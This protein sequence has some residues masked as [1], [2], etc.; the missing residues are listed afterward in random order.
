MLDL[1]VFV[2]RLKQVIAWTAHLTQSFDFTVNRQPGNLGT[3][4]RQLNPLIDG[5]PLFTIEAGYTTWNADD[6]S[7]VN[8]KLA[9]Q[10]AFEQRDNATV[11]LTFDFSSFQ[12]LGR[13]LC[14]ETMVTTH[15]GAAI[16]ESSCFVDESDVPPIDTWFAL[17]IF[18]R[19]DK[20]ILYCWIPKEFEL[21]MQ[22]A[23]DVEPLGSYHWLDEKPTMF[24]NQV[25]LRVKDSA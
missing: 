24:Y 18:P 8:Y 19:H 2:P 5:E 21:I 7:I 4:F 3:V 14:F 25:L 6:Y 10:A 17:E 13:I 16:A 22:R 11:R 23:I 15:D 1:A 9:L 20:V 12:K